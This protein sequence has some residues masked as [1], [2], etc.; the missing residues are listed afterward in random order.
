MFYIDPF[1]PDAGRT[2]S[3]AISIFIFSENDFIISSN[4]QIAFF[5]SEENYTVKKMGFKWENLFTINSIWGTT[6]KDFYVVGSGGNIAHYNGSSWTKIESGTDLQIN[7]IWGDYNERNDKWEILA[8]ASDK[9]QNNV[10]KVFKI[11]GGIVK[12]IQTIGL[13][14][15][16]SSLWFKS[17][18][19]Y[20]IVGDGYYSAKDYTLDW[21]RD[22]S[23]PRLYKHAIK[24]EAFN[25]IALCGAYGL[26]SYFNGVKWYS[27]ENAEQQKYLNIDIKKNTI[28]AVGTLHSVEACIT[29]GRR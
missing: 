7:D 5:N 23:F 26:L 19:G 11:E 1:Q 21:Q 29:L 9:Y 8:V 6:S 24:G 20:I 4:A 17:A 27:V 15:S 10:M 13:P 18:R 3:E 25:S 14:W 12:E 28:A 16:L 2:A 22:T